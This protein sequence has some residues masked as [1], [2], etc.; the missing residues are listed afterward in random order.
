M[1]E[2]EKAKR[3]HRCCFTGHRPE[4]LRLGEQE[5][6]RA[7]LDEIE[8]ALSDGYTVFVC[9]MAR[10]VDLWAGEMILSLRET[11]PDIKLICAVP[12]DGVEHRWSPE[13]QQRFWAVRQA[14]DYVQI[15]SPRYHRG[16]F[17]QR[18]RWMVE[19]ADCVVAYV[20]ASYGG[21]SATLHHAR[22]RG[23][24]VCAYPALHP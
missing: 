14:A 19:N 11:R 2:T 9:G 22:A 20:L 24:A 12:Y 4:K 15:V 13:W 23:C 18:N 16:V 17:A 1:P 7:L 8:A 21:A 10:G 6:R 5:I 3:E